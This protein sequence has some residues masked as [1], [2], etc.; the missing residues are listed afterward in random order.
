ME[1]FHRTYSHR[2]PGRYQPRK[3]TANDQDQQSLHGV[4][5]TDA[6]IAV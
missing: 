2:T 3:S 4:T 6:R 5:K 1:G